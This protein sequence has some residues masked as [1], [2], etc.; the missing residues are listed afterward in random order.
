M[1]VKESR[2]GHPEGNER[3]KLEL[4]TRLGQTSDL[5]SVMFPEEQSEV[6]HVIAP[7]F[8]RPS[9]SLRGQDISDQ[10]FQLSQ[11]TKEFHVFFH[12][13]AGEWDGEDYSPPT[14]VW[15]VSPPKSSCFIGKFSSDCHTSGDLPGLGLTVYLPQ[16]GRILTPEELKLYTKDGFLDVDRFCYF[17]DEGF[18]YDRTKPES[19]LTEMVERH[20]IASLEGA[21][22]I[23]ESLKEAKEIHPEQVAFEL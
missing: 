15:E 3:Y 9:I 16:P 6:W 19:V 14:H 10:L 12:A 13:M 4:A 17:Q 20:P 7:Q 21:L 18:W 23:L 5:L 11:S 8:K 2:I 1:V 22:W